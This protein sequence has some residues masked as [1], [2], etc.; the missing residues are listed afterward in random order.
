[1]SRSLVIALDSSD[2]SARALP[3]AQA[4][5]EQW[6]GRLILVRA[7][8]SEDGVA[9]VPLELELHDLVRKLS[10]EGI[11]ADAVV[12]AAEPAQAIVDV[13]TER[14]ADLIVMASHQRHGL[15]R[16]LN[17]SIT[18]K[19]LSLSRTPL[20]VVPSHTTTTRTR[21]QRILIPL[22]GTGVGEA[23]LDFLRDRATTRP[24][25]VLLL[26][27]VS[28]APIVEKVKHHFPRRRL[29]PTEMAAEVHDAS[30]YLAGLA[31]SISDDR[32][33]AHYRVIEAAEPVP[34]VIL[35]TA[36]REGADL[37]AL[38]SHAKSGISRLVLGS[39]SE[40]ILERSPIPVLLLRQKVAAP[41]PPL[42]PVLMPAAAASHAPKP[43]STRRSAGWQVRGSACAAV[44]GT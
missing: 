32:V 15:D 27:V 24:I 7:S 33:S 16:W 40:E 1:M 22:D 43:D 18:E 20:L 11:N 36:R 4:I 17:G 28:D 3:F 8:S 29:T 44:A 34:R 5:A 30:R 14:G 26:R 21:S 38:G 35:R 41:R 9:P 31:E 12:R 19:V 2:F 6:R 13:A 25:D 42:G 39:V 23:P 37:I 10:E